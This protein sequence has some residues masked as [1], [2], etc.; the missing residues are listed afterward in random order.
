MGAI[1]Y[2]QIRTLCESKG[3]KATVQHFEDAF[4]ERQLNA[5]DF[6]LYQLAKAIVPNGSDWLRDLASRRGGFRNLREAMQAVDT[7]AFS[8]ITGQIVYNKVL[9][10][11]E[12]PELLWPNLIESRE[13]Q[14][15]NGEIL[16]NIGEVGD[17]FTNP[18][19]EGNPYPNIGLN[20]EFVSTQPL[21]KR[22]GIVNVT[23]EILIADRTGLLGER[24]TSGMQGLGVNMERRVLKIV[25]GV[26]N[27]YKRNLVATNTYLTSGAYINSQ[28]NTLVDHTDLANAEVLLSAITNP[29]TGLFIHQEPNAIIVP[30]ELKKT[31]WRAL[32]ATEVAIVDNQANA[33]TVRQFSPTPGTLWDK[34]Y[35]T[36]MVYSNPYVKEA[37]NS[38][39]TWFYGNPKKSFLRLY[40]WDM[41]TVTAGESSELAFTTD[42]VMRVKCSVMD[43][44]NVKNPRY[45]SKNT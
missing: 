2:K 33:G 7:S 21:Q 14:F 15:L 17:Q 31:A 34:R 12:S 22:G 4:R 40:A 29:N 27:P 30:L 41:E 1:N 28:S 37:T 26:T 32:N 39:T 43:S 3:K 10:E 42:V 5:S 25:L 13:T 19:E 38:A 36:V 44:V 45:M 20:E 6:N 18:V 8:A 16:P 23:R 11:D 9:D 35:G 24:A